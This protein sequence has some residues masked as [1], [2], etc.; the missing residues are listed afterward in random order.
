MGN[1]CLFVFL[2]F[3][4]PIAVYLSFTY[5]FTFAQVNE[6]REHTGNISD[7]KLTSNNNM[8][9][10]FLTNSTGIMENT[11]GMIDDAFGALKDSFGTFFG[12]N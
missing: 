12:G 9:T 6:S 3:A 8:T 7:L 4:L 5:H 1:I 10:G 2:T 11:S